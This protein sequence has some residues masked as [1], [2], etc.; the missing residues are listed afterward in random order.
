MSKKLEYQP[1]INQNIYDNINFLK[2]VSKTKSIR[3]RNRI[4]RKATPLELL[5]IIES[6]LNIVKSQFKLTTRQKNRILPHLCFFRRLSRIRS[7]RGARQL[8]QKGDGVALP[9][10]LTPIII[11]VLHKI[12]SR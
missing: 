4:L 7:E 11:E 2:V 9:A 12:L 1:T 3:K 5:A 8:V 10:I 6:A